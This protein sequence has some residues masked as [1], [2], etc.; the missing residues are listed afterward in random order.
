MISSIH[1]TEEASQQL[2]MLKGKTGLT[3]NIL[4]RIGFSLSLNDPSIPDPENFPPDG[5][6]IIE[7]QVLFGEWEDLILSLLKERCKE[8]SIKEE[9]WS[10]YLKAH[11]NRG[12]LLLNKRVKK[13]EDIARLLP[14]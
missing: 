5:D 13:I 7:K 6:R 14:N 10:E 12:A 8:D 3:P 11:F 4:A 1:F 9:E 2:G